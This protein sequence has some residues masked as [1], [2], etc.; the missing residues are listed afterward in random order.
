[1]WFASIQCEVPDSENQASGEVGIDLGIKDLATLSDGTKY[2]NPRVERKYRKKIAYAQRRPHR[3][4]KGSMDRRKAQNLLAKLYYRAACARKDYT[5]KFTSEIA[6]K[7]A[8]VCLEDLNVRGMQANDRFAR[9]VGDAALAEIRRQFEY[10]AN[11]V[12][13]VDRFAPS[14]KTC[15]RERIL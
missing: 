13:Y 6:V 15:I 12:R 2:E 5:H 9:A 3:R 10:K 14:S 7:Y 8:A 4:K 11:E 1:M